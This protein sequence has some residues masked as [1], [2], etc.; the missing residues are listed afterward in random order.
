MKTDKNQTPEQK[1]SPKNG[2]LTEKK[3]HFSPEK[4]PT[5]G[6]F[7]FPDE[8]VFSPVVKPSEPK[9]T[10]PNIPAELF[11][12]SSKLED[13][14]GHP[15]NP[16]EKG[17][18]GFYF[19]RYVSLVMDSARDYNRALYRLRRAHVHDQ[20]NHVNSP[21][22]RRMPP[23]S[24]EDPSLAIPPKA[25]TSMPEEMTSALFAKIEADF[26]RAA[27]RLET[28]LMP[29]ADPP[30]TSVHDPV[31]GIEL[32]VKGNVDCIR[33]NDYIISVRIGA[34]VSDKKAPAAESID[35]EF[36]EPAFSSS[37]HTSI[38]S[39]FSSFS[40]TTASPTTTWHAG[41]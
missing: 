26:V 21:A 9:I 7:K 11:G 23:L 33:V 34:S 25:T 39:A 37:S 30:K 8:F 12:A 29:D 31:E 14:V 27:T 38:S 1:S 5:K 22:F 20:H 40:S 32:F 2:S 35:I 10:E 28:Y 19:D 16:A 17:T 24:D 18:P 41:P 36:F 6:T 13:I 15:F 3:K 4:D